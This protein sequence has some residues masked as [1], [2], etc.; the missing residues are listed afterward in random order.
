MRI[1]KKTILAIGLIASSL[2]LNSCD[3]NDNNVVLR[4]PTA[5]VTVYPSAPDGFFMQLDESMSLVPTNMKASP[6][7]DKK[8]RALVNYTIEEESYGGNQLSVYVNWID[9]IRTKQSVMTQ[10]SEE[11]DAKAF[12]NDPIEIVRDWVSVA[13]D[14]YVTLRIRTL[15]GGI[16]KHV[17]NLVSGVNKDNVYEFDLRHNAQGDTNGRMGDALIAFDLN[18]LWKKH[19]KEL[20]IKLNWLSFSGKKSAE[21]S[22]KMHTVT[23]VYNAENTLIFA[24]YRIKIEKKY[25]SQARFYIALHLRE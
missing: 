11:K 17:I 4:R 22:L 12:G 14:G 16:T 7:G 10:G 8:V 13:E 3:Y 25:F 2:T 9:S 20:K 18:S 15:W 1:T 23:S 6:F 21:L 24:S 5:L 19:P